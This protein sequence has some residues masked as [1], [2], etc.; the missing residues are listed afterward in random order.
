MSIGKNSIARAASAAAKADVPPKELT[1]ETAEKVVATT[2]IVPIT[3]DIPEKFRNISV[4][5]DMPA[6]LL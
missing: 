1:E 4:G 6:F 3:E 2:V 5:D